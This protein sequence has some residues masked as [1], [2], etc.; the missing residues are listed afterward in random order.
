MRTADDY[1]F[2]TWGRGTPV[3]KQEK[4]RLTCLPL[5]RGGVTQSAWLRSLGAAEQKRAFSGMQQ[6]AKPENALK[7]ADELCN[8][9][10]KENALV[11]LHDVLSSK[12]HRMWQPSIE[13]VILR[14]IDL[15]VELRKGKAAKEFRTSSQYFLPVRSRRRRW[16][17]SSCGWPC[18]SGCFF[19]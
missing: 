6:F 1:Y 11:A 8:V 13:D 14:F 16:A 10:Q 4:K 3:L 9:G 5:E 17:R 12:R 7:R 19:S 18:W 15:C 2:G